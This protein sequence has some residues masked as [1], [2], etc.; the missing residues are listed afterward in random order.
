MKT[1]FF[2]PYAK[3]FG[4]EIQEVGGAQGIGVDERRGRWYVAA[5]D[6]TDNGYPDGSATPILGIIDAKHGRWIENIPT[7]PR[8]PLPWIASPAESS[9]Q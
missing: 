4:R 2:D 1:V 8:T 5:P 7:D 3:R 6:M 9:C